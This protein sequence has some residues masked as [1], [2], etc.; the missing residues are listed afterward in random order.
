[1]TTTLVT[2]RRARA[3]QA[4]TL[5]EAGLR[6][7][8][9]PGAWSPARLRLRVFQGLQQPDLLLT[10]SDWTSR[11]ATEA[12]LKTSPVR[13][14]LDAL[15]VGKVDQGFYHELT[16]YEP[17]LAPVAVASCTRVACARTAMMRVLSYM[18]EVTGPRLRAQPGLVM[19][20]LY[21]DEDRPSQFLS[22]RGYE[23][24]EAYEAVRR[25]V[26]PRLDQGLRERGARM[27]YFVGQAV[28]DIAA[29]RPGEAIAGC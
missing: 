14:P 18:L 7:V 26:A 15:T 9:E 10:V 5:A 29:P 17:L 22:I 19:H 23:S 20:A 27:T 8:R 24:V 25:T 13:P 28:A 3:H 2:Q 1:M 12:Y 21:Q 4:A 16:A 6:L 11:E